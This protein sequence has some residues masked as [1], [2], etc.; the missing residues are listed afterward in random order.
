MA[1]NIGSLSSSIKNI[2]SVSMQR[3]VNDWKSAKLDLELK[4]L[5]YDPVMQ[6]AHCE[7]IKKIVREL[8]AQIASGKNR[9]NSKFGVKDYQIGNYFK[10]LVDLNKISAMCLFEITIKLNVKSYL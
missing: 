9:L 4:L 1:T 8:D 6:G 10:H 3:E 7:L 2:G 5:G